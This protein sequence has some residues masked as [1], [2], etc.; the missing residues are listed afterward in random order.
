MSREPV[1]FVVGDDR[2]LC[3]SIAFTERHG[4]RLR[5][6][7]N[8]AGGARFVPEPPCATEDP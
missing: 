5:A 4:G 3:D 6:E 8:G 1:V 2:A 7:A